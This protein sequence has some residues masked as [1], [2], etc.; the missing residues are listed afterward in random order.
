MQQSCCLQ[1]RCTSG[2]QLQG[3]GM[4]SA[5]LFDQGMMQRA[6]RTN[7]GQGQASVTLIQA[8]VQLRSMRAQTT[9]HSTVSSMMPSAGIGGLRS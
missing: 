5:V 7:Y 3:L 4:H 9:S 6:C 2:G 1:L 8:E